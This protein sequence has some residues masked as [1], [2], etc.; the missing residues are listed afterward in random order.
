MAADIPVMVNAMLTAA[1][2]H[3]IEH[4]DTRPSRLL[5]GPLAWRR[6]V[7]VDVREARILKCP[8]RQ[9]IEADVVHVLDQPEQDDPGHVQRKSRC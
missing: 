1:M 4:R 3:G 8:Q 5:N 6:K 9:I 2:A 7:R